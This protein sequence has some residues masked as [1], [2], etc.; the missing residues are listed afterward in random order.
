MSQFFPQ[1][2]S[3]TSL[4][5]GASSAK[6][7]AQEESLSG[8]VDKVLFENEENGYCVME[9]QSEG[10][11]VVIT[12]S[13][14]ALSA[15]EQV[16]CRGQWKHNPRHGW[17]LQVTSFAHT[18]P[19]SP[20]QIL[21]FLQSGC[22]K[23]IGP[24]YAQKIVNFF[25]ART[26]EIFDHA[27][28]ELLS[29]PGIGSKRQEQIVTS[30]QKHRVCHR[31]L[32]V[33]SPFGISLSLAQKIVKRL[34]EDAAELIQQNPF[35]LA[36][37]IRGVGFKRADML[38]QQMGFELH[39]PLRLQMGM[40]YLLEERLTQGHCCYPYPEL[41]DLGIEQ[42]Q[43][44]RGHLKEA[45]KV[46]EEEE[47]IAI[48]ALQKPTQTIEMVWL[49]PMKKS[50][51]ICAQRL[52]RLRFARP[53]LAVSFEA[54]DLEELQ[55]EEK[56]TLAP[57][58]LDAIKMG[59]KEKLSIITGGP[60]TGKSTITRLLVQIFA[61]HEARI[62][63][64]APTGRAA[65]RLAE[66]NAVP[67]KTIHQLLE[68][69][70]RAHQFK[71][72]SQNRLDLDLI[73]VD[74]A[75]MIDQP[76]MRS[77]VC[78]LPDFCYCVFVGDTDQLPSVGPGQVLLDLLDSKQVPH[79][80]LDQI[81]RQE[82]CSQII[83]A[84]HKI[85]HGQAPVEKQEKESDYFFIPCEDPERIATQI[86]S[87]VGGRLSHYYGFDPLKEIQV[88]SP[89]KKGPVGIETLNIR[90]QQLLMKDQR[91]VSIGYR[92]FCVGDKLMQTRNNYNKEVFN[93]DLL[94]VTHM[95]TTDQEL[96]LTTLEGRELFYEFSELDEVQHAYAVSVHKYQGSEMPCIIMPIHARHT[97][98]L[99]K[100][101]LYTA[102]TRGKKLVIFIG[103]PATF[104]AAIA[105]DYSLHRHSALREALLLA[106]S[107]ANLPF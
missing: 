74:E 81:Y 90:L 40:K 1:E 42:L 65:K 41:L 103:S 68:Y 15:G 85:L 58:Q 13:I 54:K 79:V 78:A 106:R 44:E 64:C 55:K 94:F 86:E 39:A 49:K 63:L 73:I 35:L 10:R 92:H 91:K 71:R 28:A 31:L 80:R 76:L 62:V 21:H 107:S 46:L 20:E 72:N 43:V 66:I 56:I 36:Q 29:V 93:G 8:V 89:M 12:G 3:Q 5:F 24:S 83:L 7:R 23:G 27:P 97:I 60:G 32:S 17:Q 59:L 75:S 47:H 19:Q 4:S 26:L 37:K 33:L 99:H 104:Q 51:E 18:P 82:S 96:T 98:M 30:W 95:N 84:A 57:K 100:K 48:E 45:L 53:S 2:P 34:G 77:L 14:P 52:M 38:A 9:L 69:D 67:A 61:K 25:G 11:S 22:I 50:E 105:R 70:F 102:L 88:L 101:L 6:G 87:L 16:Q